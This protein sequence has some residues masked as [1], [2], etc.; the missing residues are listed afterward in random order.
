MHKGN[1][2]D[3]PYIFYKTYTNDLLGFFLL[4]PYL[5]RCQILVGWVEVTKPNIKMTGLNWDGAN[6]AFY[7][8]VTFNN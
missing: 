2:V 3:N 8:N 1:E 5:C 7:R 6:H 4:K